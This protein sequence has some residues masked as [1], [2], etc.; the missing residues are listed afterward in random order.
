MGHASDE[1][2]DALLQYVFSLEA[3]FLGGEN[4]AIADKIATRCAWVVAV[5]D[6]ERRQTFQAVKELYERRS[7]IVH[8]DSVNNAKR[9]RSAAPDLESIRDLVR[10]ALLSILAIRETLSSDDECRRLLSRVAID[11]AIQDQISKIIE[12]AREMITPL[13]KWMEHRWGPQFQARRGE[14]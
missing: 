9:A 5:D 11:R 13:P 2:E 6:N 12:A 14:Q 3:L 7:A 8:G 1:Y 4:V 10:R